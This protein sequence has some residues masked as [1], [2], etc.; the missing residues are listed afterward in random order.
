MIAGGMQGSM[1]WGL[2]RLLL[3]A[4]LAMNA[5]PED[6]RAAV[7]PQATGGTVTVIAGTVQVQPPGGV[8]APAADGQTVTVGSRVRTGPGASAVLTFFDGTTA[9]LDADTELT[10][11]RVQ[12]GGEEPGGL[13][14]AAR[15]AAGRV[16]TQVSSLYSRGSSFEVQAA[17]T[18]AV[19]REGVGGFRVDAD[20]T[21]WCWAVAGEPLRLRGPHGAVELLAGQQIGVALEGY[22]P[23]DPGRLGVVQPRAFGAGVLEVRTEGSILA[24]I[25]TPANL[26]VGFPLADLVVNQVQDATTSVPDGPERWLRLPG[27]APGHYQLVLESWDPGP[28]GVRVAVALDGREPLVR[29]WQS[30]ATVGQRLIVDLTVPTQDGGSSAAELGE[31]RSLAGPA[32]GNFVYP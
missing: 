17:S 21:L 19:A 26:T 28:Y 16:W 8:F 27:P 23:P 11:E 30:I 5:L 18:T 7:A 6:A 22:A 2:A 15:L 10:V 3:A 4:T 29:E 25:V 20:G 24:R 14:V 32:P 13:L 1:T 9:T 31:P 12:P